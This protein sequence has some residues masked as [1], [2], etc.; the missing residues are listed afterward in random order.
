MT[1]A[2]VFDLPMELCLRL[3][4]IVGYNCANA[5]GKLFDDIVDE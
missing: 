1:N 3:M 4:A 5:E 2:N